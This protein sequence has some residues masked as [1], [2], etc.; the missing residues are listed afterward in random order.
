MPVKITLSKYDKGIDYG[1]KPRGFAYEFARAKKH[2]FI[3]RYI[4]GTI[5]K[6]NPSWK[7]TSVAEINGLYDAGLGFIPVFELTEKRP[8]PGT[9]SAAT[10]NGIADGKLAKNDL[11]ILGYPSDGP[12]LCA[13]GDTDVTNLNVDQAVAYYKGFKSQL[14]NPCGVYG[15]YDLIDALKGICPILWQANAPGWSN[16]KI[17]PLAHVLQLRTYLGYDPNIVLRPFDIYTGNSYSVE[18]DAYIFSNGVVNFNSATPAYGNLP[19]NPIVPDLKLNSKGIIVLYLQIILKRTVSPS[20]VTSGTF[21][22]A[23]INAIRT[24]QK[25]YSFLSWDGTAG[26]KSYLQVTGK[27]DRKTWNTLQN[28]IMN[29]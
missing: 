8:F 9:V 4:D 19:F 3:I 15:D 25:N 21:D 20:L 13:A 26:N 10:A 12:V 28:L 7:A 5:S 22:A 17:H 16:F 24:F 1:A 6:G 11:A 27:I 14:T 18:S 23:T 2:K 29:M